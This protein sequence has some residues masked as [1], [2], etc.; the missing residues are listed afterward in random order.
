[1]TDGRALQESVAFRRSAALPGVEIMDVDWSPRDWRWFNTAYSVVLIHNWH[2][3]AHYRGRRHVV[4]PGVGFYTEP[5]ETH[6]T[7]R[8]E[9]VGC[10][11]VFAFEP[12]IF[13]EYLLDQEIPARHA[14][15][16]KAVSPMSPSLTRS[17][18]ALS[19]AFDTAESPLEAQSCF[20]DI[21]AVMASELVEQSRP[22]GASLLPAT[23]AAE[24]VRDCLHE[25]RSGID[26]TTLAREIG[27]SR[28]QVLRAFK[29]RY[30]LP[31]HAY[32]LSLRVARARRLLQLG[33]PPG[34]VAAECGFVDQSHLTRH[35][36]QFLGVTPMAYAR[37]ASAMAQNDGVATRASLGDRDAQAERLGPDA[38]PLLQSIAYPGG[39]THLGRDTRSRKR[40]T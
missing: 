4:K 22:S 2:G 1:M 6:S 27:L 23:K 7:P 26:L 13:H 12:T 38:A 3:E 5:G 17:L 28:F 14:H 34:D 30:G 16:T 37:G 40:A 10:F 9:R 35:F 18:V 25:D 21:V 11:K 8:V 31:P 32:Q 20:T 33:M 29:R 24:R 36:R 15:L 19:R 39:A